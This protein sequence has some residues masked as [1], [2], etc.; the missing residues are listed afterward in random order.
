MLL[1]GRPGGTRAEYL[2]TPHLRLHRST[3][4]FLGKREMGKG[5]GAIRVS[6]PF[7]SLCPRRAWLSLSS[8]KTFLGFISIYFDN[9][10]P[11]PLRTRSATIGFRFLSVRLLRCCVRPPHLFRLLQI[12]GSRNNN[13]PQLALPLP[14]I[15]RT[16]VKPALLVNPLRFVEHESL[17]QATPFT[18]LSRPSCTLPLLCP[19][20][21]PPS[22]R[23]TESK[24]DLT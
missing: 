9:P 21:S 10:L 15:A 18:H 22:T 16:Y 23:G 7:Q 13:F 14:Y 3:L 5:E 6:L 4:D 19:V 11:P 8:R 2:T 17:Y 1:T 12:S 20:P 24:S